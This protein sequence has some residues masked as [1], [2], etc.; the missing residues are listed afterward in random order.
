MII[1]W[2]AITLA[3]L[4]AVLLVILLLV[5]VSVYRGPLQSG[6][7][8][9]LG[10][11]V[12]FEGDISLTPSLW[13]RIVIEDVHIANPAWASRPDFA[14]AER[15][16]FQVALLP[17]IAGDLKILS[18]ALDGV[19]IL[20]E[21]SPDGINN[22]TFKQKKPEQ[23]RQ[24]L[25]IKLM[26]ARQSVIGYRVGPDRVHRFTVVE[27]E[28]V[29]TE[30][31]RIQIQGTGKYRNV[32]F[33]LS[34][35]GGTPAEFI[36]AKPWPVE[37]MARVAETTINAEGTVSR[38]LEGEGF[39]LRVTVEGTQ[40]GELAPLFDVA[41]P[42]LGPYALSGR[43]TEADNRY[44][45]T[46]FT[47]HLGEAGTSTSLI[48]TNGTAFA[49][50][51]KPVELNIE[52]KYGNTPFNVSLIG[53][54][55][56]ELSGRRRPWPV[57]VE[58][59]A[60]GAR[61]T[62][63]GKLATPTDEQGFDAAVRINGREF[64]DLSALLD[65]KLPALGPYDLSAHAVILE[66]G[67]SVTALKGHLGS[68]NVPTRLAIA[69][70]KVT[71][72]QGEP[73]K[74]DIEGVYGDTPFVVSL[75]GGTL[76]E[77]N[78]PSR[79]W[80][81]KVEARAAG[82]TLL[83]DG[84][85]GKTITEGFDLAIKLHGKQLRKLKSLVGVTVPALGSYE[86]SGRVLGQETGYSI[87]DLSGRIGGAG[88]S[89]RVTVTKGKL[90]LPRGEPINLDIEGAYS[91]TPFAISLNGG[92]LTELTQPTKPWPITFTARGVGATLNANG[93][94]ADPIKV[95]G[96]DLQV[97]IKGERFDALEPLFGVA[98]P[99]LG[100]YELSGHIVDGDG[101]YTITGLKGEIN[102]T[103]IT[104]ALDLVT[105]GPRPHV[106][107]TLTSTTTDIAS[108]INTDGQTRADDPSSGPLN[109]AIPWNTLR[110]FDADLNIE[111]ERVIGGPT[112]IRDLAINAKL[113]NGRATFAPIQV[114]LPGLQIKGRLQLDARGDTPS[115]TLDAS[116][117]RLDV[118]K[119][120]KMFSD[121]GR[122]HGVVTNANIS[123]AGKGKTVET[124][125]EQSTFQVTLQSADIDY[126]AKEDGE[127]IPIK[128]SSAEAK[129]DHGQALEVVIEGT[130]RDLPVSSRLMT[131]SLANLAADPK[132]WPVTLSVN[133]PDASLD[134]KG[135]LTWPLDG[136]DFDLEFSLNGNKLSGLD[137]LLKVELPALGPYAVS[138]RFVNADDTYSLSE[139]EIKV[140]RN[141]V[142][143]NL[144]IVTSGPRPKLI[145]SLRA[146][147][148]DL[149]NLTKQLKAPR[150]QAPAK[151]D[152]ARLIPDVTIPTK[153]LRAMDA[154]L[155]LNLTDLFAQTTDLGDVVVKAKL[156]DGH[157]LI[158]PFKGTLSGGQLSGELD[159]D[160]T[161]DI[162]VIRFQLTGEH[163]DYGAL[164][165][166][167]EVTDAIKSVLD[168]DIDVTGRGNTLRSVLADA[169]GSAV[170]I[171][172][173]GSI[174]H[175]GLD[176]W[177]V[178]LLTGIMTVTT[179][180]LKTKK[181]TKLNCMVWPLDVTNGVARSEAILIDMPKI[182]VGG[183]GTI[184]LG[185]EELDLLLKPAR[186]KASFLSLGPPVR[187]TGTLS[188]PKTKVAGKAK[189]FGKALLP[190]FN[191][192]F[193][194]VTAEAGTGETNPCVAAIAGDD[195]PGEAPKKR[196]GLLSGFLKR[197][198]VRG[199]RANAETVEAN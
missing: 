5:D 165:K 54:S 101:R 2:S 194:L 18:L 174:G 116:I 89:M 31:Q 23:T 103:D 37:V 92:S 43:V 120:L 198:K 87:S 6:V 168:V 16:E 106:T 52:G 171:S 9:L 130:I 123:F 95:K 98:L 99:A 160:A 20:L 29:L 91:D 128:I 34:L 38:P 85:I 109:L 166:A 88:A 39:D 26:T 73:I 118:A 55:L 15:L 47:G 142:T 69:K 51:S 139:L 97:K 195:S 187:V 146:D 190:F 151:R 157:L 121:I 192:A 27:A 44:S 86:L 164:L 115:V 66:K 49:P 83:I 117:D 75:M 137:P 179:A 110:A 150:D 125:L 138:G 8:A 48:I 199:S 167:L 145:A 175:E 112:M 197:L 104:G 135:T 45:I 159:V 4:I 3:A 127:V 108:L 186:K 78:R 184:N 148:V 152:D 36:A 161:K 96:F 33:T 196:R 7:S 40:L 191:P 107:A 144:E 177:G 70:G 68:A 67:L 65:T 62:V 113:D 162:P 119:A 189:T 42:A 193:L 169:N 19:D 59:D 21:G 172:G 134:A 163:I 46:N 10:R 183:S 141:H 154:E 14:R 149:E 25:Y 132:V 170:L 63:D 41:F 84:E 124:L 114:S 77:L 156:D 82:A 57:K 24:L 178:D 105:T 140:D 188:K 79:P 81:V 181:A 182:T 74:L 90:M 155:N 136:K 126:L 32:P 1:G 35:L 71:V 50:H 53:G 56:N 185:T 93:T 133:A 80:P 176:L 147:G 102:E 100:A 158:S 17:L 143:G 111:I 76:T 11:S 22:W 129:A 122:L 28:V 153:A 131:A 64:G 180:A 72:L 94:I 58:A 60:A 173:P 61:L 30:G 13:P 12:R